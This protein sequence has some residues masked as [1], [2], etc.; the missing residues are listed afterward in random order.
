M[1]EPNGAQL[2]IFSFI[3][4]AVHAEEERQRRLEALVYWL[5]DLET[6]LSLLL[7]LNGSGGKIKALT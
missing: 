1:L 7:S 4:G 5:P 3:S 6:S 2:R